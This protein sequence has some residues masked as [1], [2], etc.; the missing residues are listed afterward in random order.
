MLSKLLEQVEITVPAVICRS[1]F[2]NNNMKYRDNRLLYYLFTFSREV[3]ENISTEIETFFIQITIMVVPGYFVTLLMKLFIV[4]KGICAI[5][6]SVVIPLN[7][8]LISP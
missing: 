7:T 1:I 2:R 4:S 6:K 8:G 3:L 5:V